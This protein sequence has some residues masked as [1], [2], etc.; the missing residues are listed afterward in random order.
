MVK[1]AVKELQ[2]VGNAKPV[3]RQPRQNK[4]QQRKLIDGAS[5]E[6]IVLLSQKATHEV[7]TQKVE[8][9]HGQDPGSVPEAE[10]QEM[11]A[12]DRAATASYAKPR[13]FDRRA[14]SGR[15]LTEANEVNEDLVKTEVGLLPPQRSSV[16]GRSVT[17]ACPAAAIPT[18]TR[19]VG[20]PPSEVFVTF[21]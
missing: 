10:L 21:C 18:A 9:L 14:A 1:T 4:A 13:C 2:Q 19:Q 17:D 20:L 6:L 11:T 7:L 3:T 15:S 5:G 16:K 8:A 12:T